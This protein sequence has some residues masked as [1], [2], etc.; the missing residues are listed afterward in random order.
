MKITDKIIS[1]PPYIST[2]WDKIDSLYMKDLELVISLKDSTTI[3]IPHLSAEI[4]EEIFAAHAAF[5]EHQVPKRQQQPQQ[6]PTAD[7]ILG[8]PFR[9]FFGTL[10]SINQALHHNPAYSDLPPLPPEIISKIEILAKAVSAQDIVNL[11]NAETGCNCV[12]CQMAR[13]LKRNTGSHE[14]PIEKSPA[15]VGEEEVSEDE[16]RFEQWDIKPL[17]DK[18][19]LVSNKLDPNEHYSVYLGDPIGCTCG[20]AHCEHIIAVLRH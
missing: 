16:L 19:Y 17:G 3:S 4:I 5:L 20:K 15:E 8:L 6:V 9:L 14:E 10:E 18:M 1:I 11:P 12:Y 13:I 7:N 2:S